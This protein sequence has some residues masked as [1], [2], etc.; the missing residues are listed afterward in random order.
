MNAIEESYEGAEQGG[1]CFSLFNHS[2]RSSMNIFRKEKDV[3]NSFVQHKRN[4]SDKDSPSPDE[5]LSMIASDMSKL[6]LQEREKAE[7]D[8]HGIGDTVVETPE[9]LT[10]CLEE[11]NH[12]LD[13]MKRGTSF[14][15]AEAIDRSY[16]S[17]V[18]FRTMFVR[19]ERY[20]P[21]DA[22]ERMIRFFDCKKELFGT[23]LL[24]K[25][26]LL[27][28]LSDDDI[29]AL[30]SGGL[31]VCPAKDSG[32]RPMLAIM[33][34]LRRYKR[35]ENMQR[36]CFYIYMVVAEDLDAQLKGIVNVS[37]AVGS[38]VFKS[39][40][41]NLRRAIPLHIAC[42]HFAYD[43]PF[44]YW[45][46]SRGVALLT[47]NHRVRF[48]SHMGSHVE[49]QYALATYGIPR[50]A[51]PVNTNGDLST[52]YHMAWLQKRRDIEESQPIPLKSIMSP[53][54][55]FTGVRS[56][57][58]PVSLASSQRSGSSPGPS[59]SL[60]HINDIR[61]SDILFGRG[62]TVVE[63]P[64]NAWFRDLVDKTMLHYESCTRME[65][66][67]IAEMIV[68]MVKDSGGRFL[69]AEDEGEFWEE[70]DDHAAR[71][72]VAHTFRNRR[73]FHFRPSLG[74]GIGGSNNGIGGSSRM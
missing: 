66:A 48:R 16:T 7:N 3:S 73:K 60:R 23:D 13:A 26:I 41:I 22:A 19:A 34:G 10:R 27:E 70:V 17:N 4:N 42:Q 51:L 36:A 44:A 52:D 14:E 71:K 55:M 63:H 29:E 15:L 49:C 68:N 50:H 18:H 74:G 54:L 30:E 58:S 6:S 31:Q 35:P 39:V 57:P 56:S 12:Y 24:V 47:K 64:G 25:D 45:S 28:H 5:V 11:M 40:Q 43:D 33:L 32:G 67:S 62:K 20:R 9:L 61:V 72:K 69:K 46:A 53:S 21:V 37:Y 38:P 65:K 1:G 2:V 59:D 8:I